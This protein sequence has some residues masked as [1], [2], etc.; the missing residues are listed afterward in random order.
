LRSAREEDGE[1]GAKGIGTT[2]RNSSQRVLLTNGNARD[3]PK[4]GEAADGRRAPKIK[5]VVRVV[6]LFL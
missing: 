5:R 4:P 6:K 2:E 1:G 3:E